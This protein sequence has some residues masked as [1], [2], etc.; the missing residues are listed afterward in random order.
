MRLWLPLPYF[1]NNL[2][3]IQLVICVVKGAVHFKNLGI[4]SPVVTNKNPGKAGRGYLR[5]VG[6]ELA[7]FPGGQD[8]K[9]KA[10]TASP[11]KLGEGGEAWL[12]CC[13]SVAEREEDRLV[14]SGGNGMAVEFARTQ[15]R[16]VALQEEVIVLHGR[17]RHSIPPERSRQATEDAEEDCM[18]PARGVGGMAGR[19]RQVRNKRR[20]Y[21][22]SP[23]AR[24][25]QRGR[26]RP[27]AGMNQR[28]SYPVHRLL[29]SQRLI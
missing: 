4:S 20:S 10:P 6:M 19:S 7:L 12:R 29:I 2:K 8:R 24:G 17:P 13:L 18:T 3:K 9:K 16:S 5:T 21:S 23:A 11:W 22:P 26:A 27:S 25:G 28:G 14:R 1:V 15:W